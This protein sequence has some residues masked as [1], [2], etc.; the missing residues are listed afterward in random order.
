LRI[1]V[2]EK[3][4]LYFSGIFLVGKI[5]SATPLGSAAHFS[6]FEKRLDKKPE[7]CHGS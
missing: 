3:N 6:A 2:F 5:V 4:Q 1:S 7:S